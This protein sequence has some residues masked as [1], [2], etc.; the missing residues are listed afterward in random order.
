MGSGREGWP[1]LN[2]IKTIWENRS[3][4]DLLLFVSYFLCLCTSLSL[5]FFSLREL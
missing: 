1:S 5:S 3:P 4:S 2:L